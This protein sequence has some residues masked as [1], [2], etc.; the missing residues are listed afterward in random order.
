IMAILNRFEL[1]ELPEG[2]ADYYH[3]L[4][5]AVKL[6]FTDRDRF[7]ADPE[8]AQVPCSM[9]LSGNN[10]EQHAASIKMD[11]ARAWPNVFQTVVTVFI[12]AADE[13]GNAVSMLQTIYFDWGSGITVGD[14]GILW[15]NRGA[16]FTLNPNHPNVLAPGKRPFHTLNPGI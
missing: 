4:V 6:A 14:T 11:S 10:I 15:H 12:A 9:L 8:Q 13:A 2:S 1:G 5:E 16:A 7:L 3:L